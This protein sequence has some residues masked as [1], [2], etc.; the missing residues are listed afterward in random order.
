MVEDL[1]SKLSAW[2]TK[3]QNDIQ[4]VKN[5]FS[6]G[7]PV[8]DSICFHC[9]QAVEKYLKMYLVSNDKEP[10]KFH[11]IGILLQ[12]CVDLDSSFR[13][14]AGIEYLTD[15]AVFLRYPDNFYNPTIEESKAAFELVKK[16][17]VFVLKKIL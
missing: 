4:T 11:N 17:E 3:A 5:E 14:L 10:G 1:K 7:K 16:V 12:Q 9:Q 8:P 6:S 13:E 15:Y 2:R